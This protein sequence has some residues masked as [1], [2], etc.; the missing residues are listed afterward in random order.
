MKHKFS[1]TSHHEPEPYVATTATNC[2]YDATTETLTAAIATTTP[3]PDENDDDPDDK[4][5]YVITETYSNI[6]SKKRHSFDID[7]Q[8]SK[9]LLMQLM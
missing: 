9:Q 3:G 2:D 5:E 8:C 7:K 1:L 6:E 4:H